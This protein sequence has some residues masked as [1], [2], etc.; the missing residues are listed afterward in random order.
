MSTDVRIDPE[1]TTAHVD[2]STV[3]VLSVLLGGVPRG[4]VAV[5]AGPDGLD[6]IAA[7][8]VMNALAQHGY[9]SYLAGGVADPTQATVAHLTERL[10]ARG[11]ED[12]QIGLI[13][14]GSGARVVLEATATRAYGAA[15]SIPRGAEQLLLPDRV[16]DVRSPWLG[17]VGLGAERELVPGLADYR[18]ELR[19][20]APEHTRI[21]GFPGADHCLRDSTDARVH[22]AAFDSWQ[23]TAEWLNIHVAPRPTPLALAWRERRRSLD[24]TS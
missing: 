24:H 3:T 2:G 23:R 12:E 1:S 17:L 14:Y 10:A 15:V 13:G 20:R 11:W 6:D 7:V 16:T 22:A 4:G 19:R 5:V 18:D 9:E 21:V 8:D